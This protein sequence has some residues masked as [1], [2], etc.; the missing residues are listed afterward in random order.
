MSTDLLSQL[1]TLHLYG[2]AEAWSELRA[3]APQRK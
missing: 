1:K 2:M 3:E